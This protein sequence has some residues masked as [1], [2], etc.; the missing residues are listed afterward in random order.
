LF[1]GPIFSREAVVA[2]RRPRHFALRTIYG[3]ALLVLI[4]TAW[5]L[6]TNT[7]DIQNAGDMARFGSIMF[8][9]LAP[10]QLALLM[11]LAAIQAASNIALEKD[12]ETLILLLM[13]RMT[14]SELVLGKLFSSLLNI[15]AMLLT[16]LPIFMMIVLFGGT[17]FY[18]VGWTFAVTGL[19][20]LAAGRLGA[21]VALWREKTFQTLALVAM[22]IVFWIGTVEGLALSG[23]SIGSFSGTSI[24]E[25]TNPFRAVINASHPTV[26]STWLRSVVPFLSVAGAISVLLSVVAI[27]KVRHWNPSRDVRPGQAVEDD[28]KVDMFTG[29]IVDDG[30]EGTKSGQGAVRE[31]EKFR[32]GHVD[33]RQRTVDVK[34]RKVWDNPV[35]WREIRT[36]AYGKKILFIRGVFW[37]LAA[38]V[39]F[40]L[41][42][43]ISSGEALKTVADSGVSIPL[44]AKPLMPFM[45]LSLVMVNALAVT[46][47][48][49]ER[50]GRA[51]DLLRVTDISPKEFLF[52]KLFGVLTISLDMILLPILLC[53]YVWFYG[54]LT[55]ENLLFLS[56]GFIT[57]QVF[58]VMLGIHCGMSYD[59]SR[60]G[61]G[62]SL[63]T[64][65]FLSLGV[66]TTILM[67]ISFAGSVEAQLAPFLAFLIGGAI[68]L[69]VTLGWNMPSKALAAASGI[70]PL[71]MFYSF[72]GASLKSY[73][74]VL[75]V[76]VAAY[77]FTTFAMML[78]R[79]SEWLVS[80]GRA[81]AN[82]DG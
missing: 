40:A 19:T 46:S 22:A 58:V 53:G 80:S 11:F 8:Q 41:Y 30:T 32:T 52:G 48:T 6:L 28:V 35:L 13:S 20:A 73:L 56:V 37:V 47:I 62:A 57:L 55:T 68:G 21:I 60:Q 61:I 38:F 24:A 43:M 18:Q 16:S 64:V 71:A 1:I 15:V 54:I 59:S 33:A 44:T 34:T 65:F 49:N 3:I 69:Y 67:M 79:L 14:N 66:A 42:S 26:T 5:L 17:S 29:K 50:D 82:V 78:P 75:I 7:Q 51:L 23:T 72:T 4:C 2:P 31:S 74:A 63:G 10:L 77:G 81:R 45:L 9:I 36:W 12:K 39:F 25:A 70:L 27:L 76:V